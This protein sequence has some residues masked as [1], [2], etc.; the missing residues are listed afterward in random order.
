VFASGKLTKFEKPDLSLNILNKIY[1]V[2]LD[3]EGRLLQTKGQ[4][5]LAVVCAPD[6]DPAQLQ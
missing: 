6:T 2:K 3:H 5:A 4:M 1:T